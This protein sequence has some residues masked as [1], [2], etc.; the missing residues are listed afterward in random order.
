M[1]NLRFPCLIWISLFEERLSYISNNIRSNVIINLR[2]LTWVLSRGAMTSTLMWAGSVL[3][4]EVV[5]TAEVRL[6]VGANSALN[7]PS[8]G[9]VGD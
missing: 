6:V 7:R 8:A 4:G 5:G 9:S 1:Y 2:D 3:G